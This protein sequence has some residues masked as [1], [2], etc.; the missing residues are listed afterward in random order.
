MHSFKNN[1]NRF[2]VLVM[3]FCKDQTLC[4]YW[5]HNCFILR[6]NWAQPSAWRSTVL[7]LSWFHSV[8]WTS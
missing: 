5:Q 4:L 7:R 3:S 2:G 8:L 6:K 1:I